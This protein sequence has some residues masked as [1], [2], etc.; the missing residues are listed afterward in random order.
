MSDRER[1]TA[2]LI[3]TH[4][5]QSAD[6]L[7]RTSE[8]GVDIERAA[9]VITEAFATG[10]RL[11]LCGNGGSAADA[12]HIAAEFTSVLRKEFFRP[13]LPALALTTDTSFLTAN[14]NDYGFDGGFER[15]VEAFVTAGDVLVAISTSG[16]SRNIVRAAEAAASKGARVIALTGGAGFATKA[17]V[18]IGVPS[19][20]VQHIQEAHTAIGHVLCRIVEDKLFA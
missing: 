6:V 1:S 3:D 2:A 19:T 12:Q 18:T 9:A 11:Y 15:L 10:H 16:Q 4:L 5:R 13:A 20:V 7:R 14:A 8:C 17:D